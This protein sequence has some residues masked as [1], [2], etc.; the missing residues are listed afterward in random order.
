[1]AVLSLLEDLGKALPGEDEPKM[2][3]FHELAKHA[4]QYFSADTYTIP[5]PVESREILNPLN[6]LIAYLKAK[7]AG[8]RRRRSRSLSE[9]S[10]AEKIMIKTIQRDLKGLKYAKFL[11]DNGL[12]PP[13]EWQAKTYVDAY[14]Y[15]E[16]KARIQSQ[17]S[18]VART[19]GLLTKRRKRKNK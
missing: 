16:L 18:Y 5:H 17:K 12:K 15:P 4:A 8:P 9:A 13:R 19:F 11:D 7:L 3:A 6:I 1:V 14:R 2:R 10:P